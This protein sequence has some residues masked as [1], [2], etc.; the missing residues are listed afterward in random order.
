V[1]TTI[2]S[3]GATPASSGSCSSSSGVRSVPMTAKFPSA[4]SNMSGQVQFVALPRADGGRPTRRLTCDA[5][6]APWTRGSD[7]PDASS[8]PCRLHR[9]AYPG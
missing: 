4:N 2:L 3:Y 1:M 8:T 5:G 7:D 9:G 6:R